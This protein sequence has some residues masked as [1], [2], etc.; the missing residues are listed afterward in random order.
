MPL[1]KAGCVETLGRFVF[2]QQEH[3]GGVFVEAV[4]QPQRFRAWPAAAENLQQPGGSG[5]VLGYGYT[6]WFVE[7][8]KVLV[9]IQNGNRGFFHWFRF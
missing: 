8:Q 3:P 6:G 7:N 1:G 4:N 9:L 2:C 5:T